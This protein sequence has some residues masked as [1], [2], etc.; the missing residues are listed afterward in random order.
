MRAACGPETSCPLI[1]AHSS[2][3]MATWPTWA[4]W[5]QAPTLMPPLDPPGLPWPRAAMAGLP[6]WT[7]SESRANYFAPGG[8]VRWSGRAQG[9]HPLPW[10]GAR[11]GAS[12][13]SW[14]ARSEV[15][16]VAGPELF[17]RVLEGPKWHL[18]EAGGP[19]RWPPHPTPCIPVCPS[20]LLPFHVGGHLASG[21]EGA[22]RAWRPFQCV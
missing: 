21:E 18:W 14:T 2:C 16:N 6:L 3:Q 11:P 1:S 8:P 15:Q 9:H 12:A 13:S 4:N 7:S 19:D 10:P 17:I 5:R 20:M 22:V